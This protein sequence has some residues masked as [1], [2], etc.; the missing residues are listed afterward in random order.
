ML[1]AF[2]RKSAIAIAA[3]THAGNFWRKA[4]AS[5]APVT[6]PIRAHIICTAHISG[7]VSSAVQSSVVP[8]CAPAIE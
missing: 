8:D 4:V 5:P 7:K 2:A 3:S 6:I 1:I